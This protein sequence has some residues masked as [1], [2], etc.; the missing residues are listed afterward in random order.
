MA[1]FVLNCSKDSLWRFNAS[2][3][4][5]ESLSDADALLRRRCIFSSENRRMP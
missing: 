1:F 4:V 2:L 3:E 5:G